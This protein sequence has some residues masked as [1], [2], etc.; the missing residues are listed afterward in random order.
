MVY[1]KSIEKRSLTIG[2]IVVV[3]IIVIIIL[4]TLIKLLQLLLL[5]GIKAAS[6]SKLNLKIWQ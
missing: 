4:L 2:L 1:L 5:L 6:C 3:I